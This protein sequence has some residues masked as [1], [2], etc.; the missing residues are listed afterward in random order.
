MNETEKP[1]VAPPAAV[2]TDLPA[3]PPP[4]ESATVPDAA[5][6]AEK[7][8]DPGA[9]SAPPGG[10]QARPE[11]LRRMQDKQEKQGPIS[12]TRTIKSLDIDEEQELQDAMGGMS[13]EQLL[14]PPEKKHDKDKPRGGPPAPLKGKVVAIHAADVFIDI[15]GGRSQGVL[16]SA[17]FP[18]G[19][20]AIGTEVEVKIERYDPANGLLL[21]SRKGQAQEVDWSSVQ[22]G[23]V[24]EA[25]ITGTNTGGLSVSVNNIRG[26]MPISQIDIYRVEDKDQYVGKKL[27]C[28]I[29]EANAEEKN[30]VVSRRNLLEREREENRE[31]IWAELAEGQTREG[32]VRTIKDFGAFV[33]LGGVDGLVHVSEMSWVH[34]KSAADV[35][36]PGQKVKVVVLKIDREKRKL[37]LGMK[38]LMDSPWD[39][40]FDRYGPGSRVKG[41]VTRV[42]EFGAFVELEPAV[43]GL[44]HISE[45]SP[46]RVRR[47]SD[48]VKAG[49]EVEVL[50]LNID[51]E[52]RRIALSMKAA[53]PVDAA[54]ETPAEEEDEGPVEP[55]KPRVRTTPLRGGTGRALNLSDLLPPKTES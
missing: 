45:L 35:V 3:A 52:Q 28:E 13:A 33:D 44:I 47:V 43:E 25:F 46:N 27:L 41:V 15:P 6:G 8:A 21:L 17:Q 7:P 31:K 54:P 39:N 22:V 50:V 12:L 32:I 37:S 49:Q 26:F 38:Q 34:V 16:P 9:P 2:N 18:E 55:P 24:V 48:I 14:A 40:I 36:Q 4:T 23:Q 11:L 51:P 10:S 30:L 53:M 20:P 5:A 19:I 1:N 42:Q 29:T